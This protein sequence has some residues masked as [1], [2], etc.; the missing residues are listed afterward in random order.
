MKKRIFAVALTAALA[1]TVFAGCSPYQEEKEHEFLNYMVSQPTCEEE[2]LVERVCTLCGYKEYIDISATG[3]KW[4]NG[5]CTVCGEKQDPDAP[6][7]E[8]DL[9]DPSDEPDPDG[10][11]EE[12]DPD[13]PSE[14]PD[15][16]DPSDE[17]DPD[18]PSGEPDPA[19][20]MTL[21]S[22]YERVKSLGFSYTFAEFVRAV[23]NTIF[24]DLYINANGRLKGKAD[25]IFADVGD[26][27]LDL[28]LDGESA[29]GTIIRAQ[30]RQGELI[31]TD[32]MGKTV[33]FGE[34]SRV[35]GFSDPSQ[36]TGF[37]VNLQNELLLLYRDGEI[38]KAGHI[39]N[40]LYE[41]SENFMMYLEVQ[42][43][44]AAYGPLDRNVE[45]V[46]VAPTH[47]GTPVVSVAAE[48]FSDCKKLTFAE[49]P[50]GITSIG[51]AAFLNCGKLSSIVLPSTLEQVNVSAFSHCTSLETVFFRGTQAQW[52]AVKIEDALNDEL[53]GATVYF[54]SAEEPAVPG[55][56]WRYVYGVPTVWKWVIEK[57]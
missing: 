18:D 38:V 57:S 19:A 2:G 32:R 48:A 13:D 7:D 4:V 35:S 34:L 41:Q 11:S 23:D 53:E 33:N 54:Y 47:M 17:P 44:Y 9:D 12:P 39:P 56:D 22:V 21:E 8:P 37:A 25:G 46:T 50:E 31:V 24:T 42:G 15:P 49:L 6:S 14:E 28:P 52:E 40:D 16:D 3:H 43:G 5:V 20:F 36:I 45:R 51:R 55:N 27:R 29:V 26:V 10:P 30:I 1:V